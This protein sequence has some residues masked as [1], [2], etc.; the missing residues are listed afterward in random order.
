MSNHQVLLTPFTERL[1]SSS[2]LW[3]VNVG[4]ASI[5]TIDYLA[6]AGA[7]C[8]FIDRE[9]TAINQE[10]IAPMVRTAHSHGMLAVL[11][12]ESLQ[13]ENLIRYLDRGIDGIVVPHV[14]TVEQLQM[15]REVV[16]Y[17]GKSQSRTINLIAQIESVAAVDNIAALA[18][19][20][21]ADAFLIG[22]ND[23]S[24]SLGLHGDQ[25]PALLWQRVDEVIAALNQ[26]NRAWGIP[27]NA[28][29]G[30]AFSSRGAKFLYCSV[31]QILKSGWTHFCK[32]I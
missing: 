15:L 31:E 2:P 9:R 11:R 28:Q 4:G 17:V 7:E 21:H 13:A 12:S 22:P 1:Q 27:G 20:L 25:K 14:E 32:V 30:P 19:N 10:S 3:L 24:H 5:D 26:S 16:D 6:K 29:T 23:L 18:P 8:I